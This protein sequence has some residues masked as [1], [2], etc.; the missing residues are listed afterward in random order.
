MF[1]KY[2]DQFDSIDISVCKTEKW[3]SASSFYLK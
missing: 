3:F 2:Y 1:D